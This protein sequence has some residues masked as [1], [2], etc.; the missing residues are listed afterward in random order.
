[1]RP[2]TLPAPRGGG[3]ILIVAHRGNRVHDPE[4]S[5]AGF[6]R[7]IEEGADLLETDIRP[8]LDGSFLCFHD[9]TLERMTGEHGGVES[10][11]VAELKNF[12]LKGKRGE[13]TGERIPTLEEL[14]SLL[15]GDVALAL[16]L[17]SRQFGR[18]PACRRLAKELERLGLTGRTIALSFSARRLRTLKR[19]APEIPGGHVRLLPWPGSDFEISAPPGGIL[20]LHPGFVRQAHRHGVLVCPLDPTPDRK[21]PFYKKCGVDALITDDPGATIAALRRS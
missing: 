5:L 19:E 4:N 17:K 13:M 7:A 9:P 21:I 11:T 15:P 10:S 6:R 1:V 2:I 14:A 8:S 20:T 18:P 12:R 16:E 3:D